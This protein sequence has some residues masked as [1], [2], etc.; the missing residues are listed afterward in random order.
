MKIRGVVRQSESPSSFVPPNSPETGQWFYIDIPQMARDL[1]L[2][3]E[4]IL[5]DCVREEG[6]AAAFP[7]AKEMSEHVKQSV[8]PE[9]HLS[10]AAT[11][12]ARTHE[13]WN[14]CY[15]YVNALSL[16]VCM[17]EGVNEGFVSRLIISLNCLQALLTYR[18]PHNGNQSWGF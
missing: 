3:A 7:S 10:Y 16:D 1:G 18:C 9:K 8:M 6:K 13:H 5:V 4:T 17:S 12:Y 11:W 15:D 14:Q 2:P